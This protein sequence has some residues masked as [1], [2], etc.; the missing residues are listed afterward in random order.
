VVHPWFGDMPRWGHAAEGTHTTRGVPATI[1]LESSWRHGK[2]PGRLAAGGSRHRPS[3]HR[4]WAI[5]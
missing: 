3:P 1:S 4:V 2:L 5:D